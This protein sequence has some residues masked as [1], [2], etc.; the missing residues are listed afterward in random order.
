MSKTQVFAWEVEKKK[1]KVILK[2]ALDSFNNKRDTTSE[3][4]LV[5]AALALLDL[6]AST[7]PKVRGVKQHAQ[8]ISMW[9]HP[10]GCH[11]T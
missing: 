8:D 4:E 6:F 11:Y 9:S 5:N 2:T 1:V 7:L 3:L 10:K